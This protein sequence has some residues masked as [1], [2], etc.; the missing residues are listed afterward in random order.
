VCL[1]RHPLLLE[2]S[3]GPGEAG[4]EEGDLDDDL[5]GALEGMTIHGN[6]KGDDIGISATG[7]SS[8]SSSSN[9]S[10]STARGGGGQSRSV[11]ANSNVFELLGRNPTSDEVFQV[12]FYCQ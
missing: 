9:S 11:R 4:N 1:F 3:A 8:N 2:C 7:S 10:S 12:P 6:N 5:S